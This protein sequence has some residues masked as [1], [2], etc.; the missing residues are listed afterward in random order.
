MPIS[1]RSLLF[2]LT[3]IA[4]SVVSIGA[5]QTEGERFAPLVDHHQHLLSPASAAAKLPETRLPDALAALLRER[6]LRWNN[7]VG[8]AVLFAEDG[9]LFIHRRWLNSPRAAA[10][11]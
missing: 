2:L 8:L 1:T 3:L 10:E 5:G 4:A 11:T 7:A 9:A 6:E